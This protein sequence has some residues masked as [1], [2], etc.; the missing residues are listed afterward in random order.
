MSM[1]QAAA[2]LIIEK[3]AESFKIHRSLI[4]TAYREIESIKFHHLALEKYTRESKLF[5]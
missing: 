2:P 4:V 5:L 3:M 1:M